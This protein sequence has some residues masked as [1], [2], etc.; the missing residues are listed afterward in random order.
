MEEYLIMVLYGL[1]LLILFFYGMRKIRRQSRAIKTLKSAKASKLT[2]PPSLHPLFDPTQCIGCGSCV[3]AC[4]E[5][6]VIGLINRKAQLI[7]P[8]HC[9]GHG[10]CKLAC[11]VDAITLV[12]GSENRGIDIPKIG[13]DFQTDIPGIY[14]AGELGG[15]GL[16]RNAIEQGRQALEAIA[17]AKSKSKKNQFD[18]IIVGAGPSGFA[19]SLGAIK[20][21]L[22]YLTLEQ[23]EFGGTVANFPRGKLVM[24][25]T[26]TLPLEG[27]IKLKETSKEALLAL[28]NRI[29][30]KYSVKINANE[31]M[32]KIEVGNSTIKITT[33]KS[34]YTTSNLLLC[35]GRRGTP[36]KLGVPGE[37]KTKVVYRLTD[38]EQYEG[39]HVLIVGGGDSA[40]EAAHSIA[41]QTGTKVTISYRSESFSRAKEK[42]RDKVL[43]YQ[44][45]GIMDI[46]FKT[47]VKEIFDDKVIIDNQG[48][49]ITIKNNAVIVSAGGILPTPMLKEIGIIIDTKYGTE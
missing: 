9:I 25:S 1:P 14:I 16:I 38:P 24:T 21:K 7:N 23:D 19:A 48:K 17:K 46:L 47:T 5:G 20:A 28:W 41:E 10:A 22:S 30:K 18:V 32:E 49:D 3:T 4:P 11:P 31:R 36:R 26:V 37:N 13:P 42:N 45:E 40:L 6:N 2:E 43:K 15:M 29:F 39:Q 34:S 44:R 8:T 12:F 27:K 33:S 35:I